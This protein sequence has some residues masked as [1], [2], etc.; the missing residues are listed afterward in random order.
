MVVERWVLA[1]IYKLTFC[2]LSLAGGL[3]KGRAGFIGEHWK[4]MRRQRG[5]QARLEEKT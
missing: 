5:G 1:I 2:N 4:K 3:N